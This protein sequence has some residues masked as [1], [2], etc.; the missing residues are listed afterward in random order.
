MN[1]IDWVKISLEIFSDDKIKIIRSRDNGDQLALIWIMLIIQAAKTNAGGSIYISENIPYNSETLAVIFSLKKDTI[2][3][4]LE[5]FSA[6]EM[7][8]IDEKGFIYLPNF[9]RYQNIEAFESVKEQNRLRQQRFRNKQKMLSNVTDNVTT[10]KSNDIE[11]KNIRI[12]K[13]EIEKEKEEINVKGKTSRFSAPPKE[14]VISFFISEK[15]LNKED[16][17]YFSNRFILFYDSKN[18]MVGK[19]KMTNWKTAAVRSLEWEDKRS[20]CRFGYNQIDEKEI[21]KQLAS[22]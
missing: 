22:K 11:Y 15:G 1:K 17:E 14:D 2:N 7:I 9:G 3:K 18:W 6:L 4:A 8:E 16:S 12:E 13:K 21:F 20:K 10:V 19:N 5:T